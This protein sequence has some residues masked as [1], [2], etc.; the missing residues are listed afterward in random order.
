MYNLEDVV[1]VTWSGK[2]LRNKTIAEMV[3]SATK[4]FG[5]SKEDSYLLEKVLIEYVTGA[6]SPEKGAYP[7]LTVS[8]ALDYLEEACLSGE[9]TS[10]L[11]G[12]DECSAIAV[13]EV[14]RNY[15]TKVVGYRD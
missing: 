1:T 14:M 13:K 4:S 2:K 10:T 7:S 8:T 6:A 15:I 5:L 11:L 3:R 12:K 9:G